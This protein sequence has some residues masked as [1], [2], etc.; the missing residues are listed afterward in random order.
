MK[1]IYIYDTLCGWCN[2]ARPKIIAL[3]NKINEYNDGSSEKIHFE[4]IHYNMFEKH[5]I[6]QLNGDFLEMVKRV[7]FEVAPK[8]QGGK[9]S[10]EYINLLSSGKFIHNSDRSSLACT[11]MREKLNFDD[12]FDFSM[13]LQAMLFEQGIAIDDMNVLEALSE[14]YG[15]DAEVFAEALVSEEIM[16]IKNYNKSAATAFM[17]QQGINGVPALITEN[18]G[19]ELSSLNPH[20]LGKTLQ[21]LNLV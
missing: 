11:V 12:Y 20:N 9:F 5:D 1:V 3:R 4:A 16:K 10:Q 8:M 13:E 18:S 21:I 2:M 14:K 6:S 17:N 15:L 7:A 19:G